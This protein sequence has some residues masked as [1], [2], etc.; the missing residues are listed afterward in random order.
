MILGTYANLGAIDEHQSGVDIP[1]D[2]LPDIHVT[3]APDDI[4]IL[5][6]KIEQPNYK[7]N[8][9]PNKPI[10]TLLDANS[11]VKIPKRKLIKSN[12][13]KELQPAPIETARE[14]NLV[15]NVV[16][17][18]NRPEPIVNEKPIV[19]QNESPL[20]VQS[21]LNA[22][23]GDKPKSIVASQD[24]APTKLPE[25][26]LQNDSLINKDAIQK[27][28]REIEFNAKEQRKNDVE[29]TQEI[30]NAVKNQLSK[31]NEAN[32]KIVLEKINEISEKVN[33]IAQKDEQLVPLDPLNLDKTNDL[34]ANKNDENVAAP[35]KHTHDLPNENDQLKKPVPLVPIA[36]LLAE[37]KMSSVSDQLNEP[38][39]EIKPTASISVGAK[40]AE[41]TVKGPNVAEA[42]QKLPSPD[43]VKIEKNANVGR[44]LL[45]HQTAQA[46]VI[47]AN[48]AD[49]TE[50]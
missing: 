36:K 38:K 43:P 20:K 4:H 14:I 33:K 10:D 39:I 26:K 9:M 48:Q 18:A 47:D 6:P 30:L 37:H 25:K 8:V 16:E 46:D 32:H 1:I 7:A 11:K 28:E 34:L 40:P 13:T 19:Q 29:R 44:D 42:A 41:N 45:S 15:E 35:N 2:R 24:S 21:N 22:K 49:K 31:Q 5:P 12:K 23:S 50:N 3:H 17:P 27:E